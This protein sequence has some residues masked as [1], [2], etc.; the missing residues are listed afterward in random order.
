MDPSNADP[1]MTVTLYSLPDCQACYATA[2]WLDKHEI[3]YTVES[4]E[5]HPAV[6]ADARDNGITAA[7]VVKVVKA[8]G[9]VVMWGGFR[10]NHLAALAALKE[11]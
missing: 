11:K 10:I 7:P 9:E 6:L 5:D 4:L 2:T 3:P 8:N 1:P